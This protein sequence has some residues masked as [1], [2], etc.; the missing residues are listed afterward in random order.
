M[1]RLILPLM[2]LFAASAVAAAD[3]SASSYGAKGDGVTNDSA[4]IQRAMDS[5][6]K[7]NGGRV[8]LDSGK[9]LIGTA[10]TV[11][12]GVTL[13]GVW[14]GPHFPPQGTLL[15]AAANKGEENGPPLIHLLSNATIK[16]VTIFHPDQNLDKIV[17]YPWTIRGTGTNCNVIDVT[18]VNPTK[19][20]DVGTDSNELHY[21]RNVFGCPLQKGIYIDKTTDI[22]RVENVHFNPNFWDRSGFANAPKGDDLIAYLNANCTS[23]ELG[24]SDWEFMTNTFSFG[25]KVGYRFFGSGNGSCN[26]N[27][28][29]IAADWARTAVLVEET[30]PPALLITNGEFVGSPESEACVEVAKSNT[31][32]VQ[33]ENCA[34]WGPMQRV[35]HVAGS[36]RAQF[37]NCNFVQW[38]S[39]NKGLPAIEVLSGDVDISH[40]DFKDDKLQIT[41]GEDVTATIVANHVAGDVRITNKSKADT[42]VAGNVSRKKR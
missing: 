5:A 2:V 13:A 4:A 20:I 23:F 39:H 19:G 26:G 7:A 16:G 1:L 29:G 11:P 12:E 21:I 27:F 40:C 41:L 34:F 25:C 36:G 3:T 30:Q 14:D 24:R 35:A 15:L 31:G 38:D 8:L 6:A 17:A 9:Y 28:Q 37:A 10:L 42:Y 22:G 32:S 33:F 18:L